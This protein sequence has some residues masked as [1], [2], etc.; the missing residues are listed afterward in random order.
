MYLYYIAYIARRRARARSRGAGRATGVAHLSIKYESIT[1][2]L[3]PKPPI[4]RSIN[5]T[6]QHPARAARPDRDRAAPDARRA[7]SRLYIKYESITIH[8]TPNHPYID[9]SHAPD[10]IAIA[11]RPRV[12]DGFRGVGASDTNA[13]RLPRVARSRRGGVARRSSGRGHVYTPRTH[14]RRVR[15]RTAN[16]ARTQRHPRR[17]KAS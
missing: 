2:T 11:R 7:I 10:P 15:T 13:A 3:H 8:Y 5:R 6:P 1:Y 9:Q 4:Y 12:A 14:A 17:E 16:A